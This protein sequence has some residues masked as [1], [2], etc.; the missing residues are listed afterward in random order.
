MPKD[1]YKKYYFWVCILTFICL[2]MSGGYYEICGALVGGALFCLLFWY[3]NKSKIFFYI[4]DNIFAL[5]VITI[6]YILS[7]TWAVDKTCAIWGISKIFPVLLYAICVM[8]LKDKDINSLIFNLPYFAVFLVVISFVLQFVPFLNKQIVINGRFGGTFGYPNSFAVFLLICLWISM[9]MESKYTPIVKGGILAGIVL[10]GS[11]SVFVLTSVVLIF[12]LFYSIRKK[13]KIWIFLLTILGAVACALILNEIMGFSVVSHISGTVSENRTSTFWGRI[14]YYK[15]AIPVIIKHP[16]GL[17]YL[18]YYFMQGNFQ[19]GVYTVR[20]IHNDFLQLLLDIGWIPGIMFFVAVI[21]SFLSKNIG[22]MQKGMLAILVVHGMFDFN[23]EFIAMWLILVTCL[24]IKAGKEKSIKFAVGSRTIVAV[25]GAGIVLFSG[26]MGVVSSAVY[27]EKYDFVD[28]I[29]PGNT[30][31]EMK[32]LT[33]ADNA[34]EMELHAEKILSHNQYV[35]LA[36]D[37]KAKVAYSK[38]DFEGVINCKEKAIECNR[39]DI[40]EYID[41]FNMLKAGYMAYLEM[42]DVYSAKICYET[43]AG[44][45]SKLDTVKSTTDNLA[46]KLRDSPELEMPEDYKF[47]ILEGGIL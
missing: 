5:I 3:S 13:K 34:N 30:F 26:Y 47:F 2:I 19:H 11:R 36:W 45:Q 7:I 27:L 6:A 28:K 43:A 22:L 17:G 38:G 10:S 29:Y 4:N 46:W 21:R 33:E 41:Y 24:D 42:G 18:G 16:F 1:L 23:M 12:E 14:L 39:Y 20:W 40:E 15:D 35:A 25:L 37:A 8:Q 31:V 44:I 32:R 9:W